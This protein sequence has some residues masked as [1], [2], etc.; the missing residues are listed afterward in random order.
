VENGLPENTVTALAQTS[1]GF[2]WCATPSALARF[3]GSRFEVFDATKIPALASETLRQLHADQDGSLWI[4]TEE[5][6]L[7][8][9]QNGRF[10]SFQPHSEETPADPLERKPAAITA[11]TRDAQNTLWTLNELGELHRLHAG[12]LTLGP[13]QWR[14]DA[15][16][17]FH[18]TT[19]P[20]GQTWISSRQ[21]LLHLLPHE[22]V[23][24]LSGAFSQYQ[25]LTPARHGGWWIALGGQ[26]RLWKRNRWEAERGAPTWE[27]FG[28]RAA[29][30]D[31][32]GYLW[33]ASGR[34]LSRFDADGDVETFTTENGLGS[35]DILCLC[36]DFQGDLWVGTRGGGLHRIHRALFQT[37]SRA[38]GLPSEAITALVHGAPN[39]VWIGTAK[40]GVHRIKDGML[41][42]SPPDPTLGSTPITSLLFDSSERLWVGTASGKLYLRKNDSLRLIPAVGTGTG[43]IQ[44]L[45][46]D[47]RKQIWVGQQNSLSL[48]K[49]E[50]QRV[51]PSP[52]LG[53][54]GHL[55]ITSIAE[56]PDGALW[57]G[58]EAHG[59][60][61]TG[62]GTE[63]RFGRPEGLPVES[64]HCLRP[65]REP[66]SLW[67]GTAG[68]G[69]VY[70]HQN[71]FT[72]IATREGLP[73]LHI[74]GIEEDPQER[75]WLRSQQGILRVPL[76][77]LE[78]FL[79]GKK[80]KIPCTVFGLSDGLPSL[81][82]PLDAHPV[83]CRSADGRLWF[84][85]P[86]GLAAT[87]PGDLA[88]AEIL[89]Q[90][91]L[92][93]GRIDG[94]TKA[95]RA[96]CGPQITAMSAPPG[97]R[98]YEFFYTGISLR[99]PERLRF[100][101]RL[102]G[103]DSAWTES[104]S[105]RSA[106]YGAL[107]P[108]NYRFVVQAGTPEGG[109]NPPG[110]SLSLR[111]QPRLWERPWALP[112]AALL[113]GLSIAAS[114]RALTRRRWRR[115][116]REVELQKQLEAER[117]RIAQDIHDDLGAGLTQI[118]WLGEMTS[119][120]SERPEEVRKH[121]QKIVRTS[122]E[123]VSSLDEIVWAVRPQNDSLQSL[124]EYLGRRVD[125]LFEN[126]PI[127][128]WF[129]APAQ[130]PN[131]QIQSDQRHQFFMTCK[132][133]LHN[134]LKHS[135]ATEV[136]I[137]LTLPAP[138]QLRL[139]IQDNGRGFLLESARPEGN[140]L[141]NMH[142][143]A[144]RLQG[145]F[146]IESAPGAGCTIELLVHLAPTPQTA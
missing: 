62:I 73:D 46:E 88:P 34:G 135:A 129:H 15:S 124:V 106:R 42:P 140:G 118:D 112:L 47:S 24:V 26:V 1:D 6:T 8:H 143:R 123:M 78:A 126:S 9:L 86:R 49:V 28:V 96:V 25:F 53:T 45:F 144:S 58:T 136:H 98:Q 44:C 13:S 74:Y 67:I 83:S 103:L 68:G 2:L 5:G 77:E 39:E 97:S 133:A 4:G 66:G 128:A 76:G 132:E 51:V 91:S 95:S 7:V 31:S 119:R 104:D 79:R 75:L 48:A 109:W 101:Y 92:E 29:L 71:Q 14:E 38:H 3:D 122:R 59:L 52:W 43:A 111:V 81:E 61:R 141:R 17:P 63:T 108:G 80:R 94:Q 16:A 90:V 37:F 127:R 41:L 55:S 36:E 21:N 32:G 27:R 19:D 57:I 69:L 50:D 131:L 113:C 54:L 117:N 137:H 115:K 100:R 146:R 116:L 65:G 23:P 70:F 72:P 87:P 99:T 35:H 85:A 11:I 105:Q 89:P 102:E 93:E 130:L 82:A 12:I 142:Q 64:I 22:T 139:L 84:A 20:Q 18:L 10:E 107:P 138:H 30:E 33:I 110:A 125:E 40:S 60:L 56:T 121:S 120:L 114:A 134:V 145:S